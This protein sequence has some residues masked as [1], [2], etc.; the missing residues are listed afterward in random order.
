MKITQDDIIKVLR[1]YHPF[2]EQ[3]ADIM[4]MLQPYNE[5]VDAAVVL[6]TNCKRDNLTHPSRKVWDL[7][8]PFLPP[9]LLSE[10]LDKLADYANSV[11]MKNQLRQ[12]AAEAR[13][14][15]KC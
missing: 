8:E 1:I 14:I 5:L 11:D 12:L 7:A 2:K 13:E 3:A 4:E 10:K 15:E 6:R 9:L